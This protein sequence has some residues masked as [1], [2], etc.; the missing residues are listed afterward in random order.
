M[1]PCGCLSK[2]DLATFIDPSIT[3]SS[4]LHQGIGRDP[5]LEFGPR[6]LVALRSASALFGPTASVRG[7]AGVWGWL[8]GRLHRLVL[9]RR[10][11]VFLNNSQ[12]GP[13]TWT[14]GL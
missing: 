3:A 8:V 10:F 13:T 9:G 4:F 6:V 5:R 12:R 11:Q 1:I 2:P 7:G 14:S